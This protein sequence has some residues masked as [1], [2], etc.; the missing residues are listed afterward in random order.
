MQNFVCIIRHRVAPA[1][2][3][4]LQRDIRRQAVPTIWRRSFAR[5]QRRQVA[6]RRRGDVF[7]VSERIGERL[8]QKSLAE[9][10]SPTVKE[11]ASGNPEDDSTGA[12]E[13]GGT[14]RRARAKKD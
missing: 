8:V 9:F 5:D 13:P 14:S 3:D 10:V 6:T 2:R 11:A 12:G 7:E 1:H 4:V